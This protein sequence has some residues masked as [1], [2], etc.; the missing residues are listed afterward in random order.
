MTE[1][2]ESPP[3][4]GLPGG[5]VAAIIATT[6]SVPATV[7]RLGTP[8]FVTGTRGSWRVELADGRTVKVRSVAS[9]ERAAVL[10]QVARLTGGLP[11]AA[12]LARR[13]AAML[14]E[15][16]EGPALDSIDIDSFILRIPYLRTNNDSFSLRLSQDNSDRIVLDG[17]VDS[18]PSRKERIDLMH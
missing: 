2:P 18:Y 7:L 13:G 9:A 3:K 6:G 10:S 8:P 1:E 4:T 12:T 11:L 17:H 16:I 14:E 15:W 5:D